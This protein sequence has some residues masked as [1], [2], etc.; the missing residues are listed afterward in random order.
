MDTAVR[1]PQIGAGA[2][3]LYAVAAKTRLRAQN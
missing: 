2:E 3:L 1:S